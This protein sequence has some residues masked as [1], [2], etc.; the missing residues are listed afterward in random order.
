MKIATA[1][2][3]IDWHNSWSD[4]T[5]K[6]SRWVAE[7]AEAGANLLVFPEYGA[8][9]L[10]SLAGKDVAGDL[11]AS[12]GAVSDRIDEADAHYAQLAKA[13]GCYILASSAPVRVGAKAVNRSRFF[14]PSG[15]MV[16]QDKQIMTRFER[17]QWGISPGDPLQIIETTFGMVGI[18]ICYD[19]EFPLLARALS[20]CDILLMPSCTDALA[21]YWRVRIGT[22]AR[23][24]EQQ[25]IA[26]MAST[27]GEAAWSPAVDTNVGAG[28]VFCPPDRGFPP[29]GVLAEGTLNVAGWTYAEVDL[30]RVAAV[31]KEGQVLNR[32]HWIDQYE[33]DTLVT[34]VQ[35]T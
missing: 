32:A 27:V 29:T 30:A 1:A 24:L 26:V 15:A 21:G 13:H 19:S 28:G 17:E 34:K 5:E 11:I 8:M 7:A 25:S 22:M 14:A 6:K 9:E 4:Y 23:A 10:A 35:L 31:R 20:E 12:I 33:R 3:P 2:Y 18:L 16:V